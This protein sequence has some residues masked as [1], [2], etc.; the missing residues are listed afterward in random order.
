MDGSRL[1]T[2]TRRSFQSLRNRNYRLFFFGQLVSNTGNWLTMVALTLLVLNETHSGL[3]VG[4]LTAC[5]FGPILVLSPFAGLVADRVDK[6]RL[7]T[8]TQ[9][10]EMLQSFALAALA[11]RPHTPLGA[12]FAVAAVGGVLLAFDNP[13]R[14]SFVTE[15]VVEEDVPNAVTLYSAIVAGSRIFGPALAGALVVTVG[16]GWAFTIDGLS[17]LTV[18]VAIAMMRRSELRISPPAPRAK[19]QVRDGMRYVR[20]VPDLRISFV[21]LAII[22]ILTYN[23]S[24]TFPLLVT[25][26]LHGSDTTFTFVYSAFSVGSFTGA[27]IVAHRN[28]VQFRMIV[29]AAAAL[30]LAMLLLAGVPAPWAAFPVA[31]A[32]GLSSISYMTSTTA[33][34]QVISR[35]DMHGRVLALQTVLMIGTTPLGGPLLGWIADA[36]NARVPVLIGGVGALGAALYGWRASAVAAARTKPSARSNRPETVVS[37]GGASTSTVAVNAPDDA[38][39]TS[40][41]RNPSQRPATGYHTL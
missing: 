21:M 36:T 28:R 34:V 16:Y 30:G 3:A 5:Q 11:F 7:L 8:T 22:G 2:A 9:I 23:F 26:S 39:L 24:V 40:T 12:L 20:E 27:L 35:P 41:S 33:L 1:T 6:K 38:A 4:L 10:L 25:R 31:V 14:R 32:L 13:V 19:H 37:S 15:M 18:L 29:S 17:Y